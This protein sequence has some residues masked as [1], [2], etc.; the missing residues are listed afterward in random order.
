M[1]SVTASTNDENPGG[2]LPHILIVDDDPALR[3]LIRDFLISEGYD[4]TEAEDA[5]SMRRS[6]AQAPADIIILDV[7]MPGEDGLSIA[8]SLALDEDVRIIMVSAL[9]SE[10][11]RIIGLEVGADDYLAKPVS[12]RE[13]LARIRAL[14]RRRRHAPEMP[15]IT[16]HYGF[17][18]WSLDPVRRVLRDPSGVIISL[19]EGE[20][21][22]LLALVERPKR[23]LSRDRLLELARG[24]DSEAFDRAV[25]TQVSRLRRKLGT[26]LHGEIIRTVRNEGYMF[27]PPVTRL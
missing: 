22:L 17:E 10:T 7:M 21:G 15:A 3:R 24:Q 12:P 14:Q 11:D 16:A 13:L 9:G 18:G 4:V 2:A 5:P 6:L 25:D 26:R 23:V 20:F 1:N 27:L 19:S 8:R